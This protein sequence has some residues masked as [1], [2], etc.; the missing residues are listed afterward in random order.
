MSTRRCPLSYGVVCRE[1]YDPSKH[2]GQPVELD[3]FDKKQYAE[4]QMSWFLK[5]VSHRRR[6]LSIRNLMRPAG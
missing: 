3:K 5:Q 1:L 6:P 2:Q 4:G